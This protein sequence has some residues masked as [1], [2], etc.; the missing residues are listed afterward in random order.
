MAVLRKLR[1]AGRRTNQALLVLLVL[2]GATGVL[3]YAVGTPA[4]AHLVAVAHAVAGLALLL[5]VPWKSVIVSRGLARSATRPRRAPGGRVHGLALAALLG[6]SLL[7]GFAHALGGWHS[8]L[9]V[10]AL[11]V[12]VGAAA[13]AVPFAW[14]HVR[15]HPQRV[16]ATDLSRRAAL[17]SMLLGSAALGAYGA[18]EGSAALLGLPGRNRRATGSH[19]VGSGH[20]DLMPV[21]QWFTDSVQQVPVEGWQLLVTYGSSQHRVSYDELAAGTDVLLATLD[22]TGGWYAEQA[23][24]G[25]RLDRL[26]AGSGLLSAGGAARQHPRSVDV[27]SRTGYRRRFPLDDAPDLLLATAAGGVELS[28][29]HGA[30]LRLVAPGRRGFWW[31]KWVD[32]IELVDEPW[33]WQLPFPLQ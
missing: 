7:A 23:W 18:L 12:H 30:P 2:A 16:R 11:Q 20:P 22:C 27:V 14:S 4:T 25:V 29:G 33:G 28:A 13:I 3:A 26:L 24:R 19:D 21:T 9:G 6:A 8:L 17:R 32:R 10:T 31:V 1:R 15:Q 5:L